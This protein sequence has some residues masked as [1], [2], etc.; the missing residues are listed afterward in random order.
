MRR[1]MMK[2]RMMMMMM[3]MVIMIKDLLVRTRQLT[4]RMMK[5]KT[6]NKG[7]THHPTRGCWF[8]TEVQ[9]HPTGKGESSKGKQHT[10]GSPSLVSVL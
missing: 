1:K 2:E 6:E 8:L 4:R 7:R 9:K 3:M 5:R 10:D